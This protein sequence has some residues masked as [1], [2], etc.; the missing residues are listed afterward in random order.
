MTYPRA[1]IAVAI[2]NFKIFDWLALQIE[3]DFPT[4]T[5][6]LVHFLGLVDLGWIW[7]VWWLIGRLESSAVVHIDLQ[8]LSVKVLQGAGLELSSISQIWM[9]LSGIQTLIAIDGFSP[10]FCPITGVPQ[11]GQNFT[12]SERYLPRP[13]VERM[14]S[15]HLVD[16]SLFAKQVTLQSAFTL[17][18]YEII[19]GCRKRPQQPFLG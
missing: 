10:C 16:Q 3:R 8:W 13:Y 15:F 14:Y 9:L 6:S 1:Y 5:A 11:F 4:V 7:N 17:L 18:H 19:N 12:V 2:N